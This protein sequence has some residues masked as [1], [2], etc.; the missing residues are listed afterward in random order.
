[1]FKE[2][3]EEALRFIE[4]NEEDRWEI[5]NMVQ[6]LYSRLRESHEFKAE[7]SRLRREVSELNQKLAIKSAPKESDTTLLQQAW[8]EL[9]QTKKLPT[10]SQSR[11]GDL[12]YA[13]QELV[14]ALANRRETEWSESFAADKRLLAAYDE[15]LPYLRKV[16][17]T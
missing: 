6:G 5:G 4:E 14:D 3:E 10:R 16:H 15:A 2:E 11:E 17:A 12:E 13:L 7:A 1:M 9:E 8:D